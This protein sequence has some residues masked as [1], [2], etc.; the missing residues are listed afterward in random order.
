M[1]NGIRHFNEM[2]QCSF[3]KSPRIQE[4]EDKL[5]EYCRNTPDSLGNLAASHYWQEFKRWVKI[6]GYTQQE[7]RT[8]KDI[9]FNRCDLFTKISDK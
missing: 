4:L 1:N 5:V 7:V 8:A 6:M 2:Y 3:E 9:V